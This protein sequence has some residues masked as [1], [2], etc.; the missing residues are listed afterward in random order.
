MTD[1]GRVISSIKGDR[2]G[3]PWVKLRGYRLYGVY[4]SKGMIPLLFRYMSGVHHVHCFYFW[5]EFLL[6][7][8]AWPAGLLVVLAAWAFALVLGCEFAGLFKHPTV[9]VG[10]GGG[11]V[12]SGVNLEGSVHCF[13]QLRGYIPIPLRA[14]LPL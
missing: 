8:I 5:R 1:I 3:R 11:L 4:L 14:F 9:T 6:T 13:V 7:S 12:L 2:V 10:V